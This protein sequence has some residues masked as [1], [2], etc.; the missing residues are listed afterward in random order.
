IPERAE[1]LETLVRERPDPKPEEEK[2]GK[3]FVLVS[4][5]P[6][7]GTSLMMQMLEAGGVKP[8]TDGE[9]IAGVDNPEEEKSGKTFVLVSGLPRSG[10]SLM[11]QMLEAGGV[12]PLT[13][14]ERIADV[15]NPK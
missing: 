4:G 10:T 1:R 6:R 15:D 9:R 12:K 3:T 14:G 8:L 5:L 11:M 2:S 7:S 13:D